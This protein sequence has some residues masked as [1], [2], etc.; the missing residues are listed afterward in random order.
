MARGEERNRVGRLKVGMRAS[1]QEIENLGHVLL[2][3]LFGF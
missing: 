2:V 3:P 1:L